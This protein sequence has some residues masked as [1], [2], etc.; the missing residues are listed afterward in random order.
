MGRR[1]GIRPRLSELDTE[2]RIQLVLHR[3][4]AYAINYDVF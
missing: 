2:M 4:V 1:C 3:R